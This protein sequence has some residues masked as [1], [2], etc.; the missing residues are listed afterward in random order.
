MVYLCKR[1]IEK[2]KNIKPKPQNKKM[3]IPT[4]ANSLRF[5]EF[6]VSDCK[7][8][9]SVMEKIGV[10][11]CTLEPIQSNGRS[12]REYQAIFMGDKPV[13]VVSD[14]Y[15]LVQPIKTFAYAD[16]VL[17]KLDGFYKYA[18]FLKGGRQMFIVAG[19][20]GGTW[21][22]N[23]DEFGKEIIFWNSFDG[24]LSNSISIGTI[25]LICSN[26]LVLTKIDDVILNAKHIKN[27]EGR[28]GLAVD[29]LT[30]IKNIFAEFEGQMTA[31]ASKQV[32]NETA[33]RFIETQFKGDSTRIENIRQD[34]FNRFENGMGNRGKTAYDLFNGITEYMNHGMSF[35]NTAVA[36]AEENQF[37]SNYNGA[38]ANRMHNVLKE[39]VS[40]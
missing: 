32:D 20:N 9:S 35:R 36:S 22:I 2:R 16:A 13:S 37:S 23:Q 15:Q 6:D 29:R 40:L 26:G 5:N 11:E 7:D 3:N 31:L 19:A 27:C 12:L 28:I 18:G 25:R 10:K 21:K 17:N 30:G 8:V 39:L 34:V 24:S 38:N 1:K 14:S 4:A 33:R